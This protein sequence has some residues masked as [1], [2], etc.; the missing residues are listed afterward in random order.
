MEALDSWQEEKRSAYLY[1]VLADIEP[2]PIHQKMF[3]ELS[4]MAEQQARIWENKLRASNQAI[5]NKIHLDLR[6]RF[7]IRLLKLFGAKSLRF[8][9]AAMKIRG[10]SIYNISGTTNGKPVVETQH[11]AINSSGNLRAAVFGVSDGLLSNASLIFGIA[12]ASVNQHF[13]L[14]SGVAGLLA[15]AFSMGSGEYVSVR[16]QRQMLEYQLELERQELEL[17]PEEEAA[18]LALI[19]QT[20]GLSKQDADKFAHLLIQNPDKA[21]DVLAREELGLNPNELG[22]PWGA[23]ISSFCSFAIGATI[24]LLPFIFSQSSLNLNISIILT[25]I[26]FFAVGALISLVTGRHLLW[27]GL[28]LILIGSAVGLLTYGIGSLFGVHV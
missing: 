28:R 9:L 1:R 8:M 7:I 11:R 19:Y 13:I 15:G 5:P 22:S 17:Y 3:V 10:M 20:R 25:I 16:S 26:A 24:P 21:L 6:T 4:E 18:E 12:G 2:N 27:G 23:A 14:L